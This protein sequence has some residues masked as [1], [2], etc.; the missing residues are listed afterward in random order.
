MS[1]FRW[2]MIATPTPTNSQ[3][4][5]W[6]L[7][8][9][10]FSSLSSLALLTVL[11]SEVHLGSADIPPHFG[12]SFCNALEQINPPYPIWKG[13]SLAFMWGLL[14]CSIPRGCIDMTALKDML[15]PP[16]YYCTN[17]RWW[18]HANFFQDLSHF[19]LNRWLTDQRKRKK[20]KR[21]LNRN[22]FEG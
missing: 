14:A 9:L 8:H 19:W 22:L 11:H 2:G 10:L 12:L 1:S 16:S 3:V 4:R 6:E 7:R 15:N 20:M 13:T 17:P 18:V 5:V 21:K